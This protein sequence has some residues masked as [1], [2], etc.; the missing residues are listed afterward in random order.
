MSM[1]DER[2]ARTGDDLVTIA[3]AAAMIGMTHQGLR[4]HLAHDPDFPPAFKLL[5][6]S[7]AR[8]LWLKDDLLDW[9]RERYDY[10]ENS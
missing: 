10:V 4:W 7:Q 1:T 9:A 5:G 6:P 3:E 2:V 8:G